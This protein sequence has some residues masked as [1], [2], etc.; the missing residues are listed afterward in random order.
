MV[1]D[2]KKHGTKQADDQIHNI[3]AVTIG[4]TVLVQCHLRHAFSNS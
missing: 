2:I 4:A 3:E 1:K